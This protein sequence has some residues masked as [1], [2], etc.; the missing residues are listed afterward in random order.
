MAM[1]LWRVVRLTAALG[2]AVCL[3]G[4]DAPAPRGTQTVA[5]VGAERTQAPVTIEGIP[6]RGSYRTPQEGGSAF[7][8]REESSA[9]EMRI[10]VPPGIAVPEN[11]ESLSYVLVSGRYDGEKRMF[12]ATEVKA[13]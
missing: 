11:L 4:C 12:V 13:K 7:I 6:L 9:R 3:A 8:L 2:A 5:F 10:S 1:W